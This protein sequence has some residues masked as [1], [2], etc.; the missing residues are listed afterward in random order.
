MQKKVSILRFFLTLLLALS[1]LNCKSKNDSSVVESVAKKEKLVVKAPFEMPQLEVPIFPENEV[2]ITAFGAVE[3]GTVK[4][5]LAIEKAISTCA[6][7][8]GGRVV[9]PKGKWLT[10]KI[11]LKSHIDLHISEGAELIF[12]DDPQDYLPAVSTS[13]EGLRCYNYSPLIYAYDQERIAI[14]GKGKIYAKMDTWKEWGKKPRSKN[15]MDALVDLYEL[16]YKD[17]PIDERRMEEGNG[18]LRPHF[19]QFYN[20][21]NVLIE[22]IK[23]E[24]SPFWV[25]HMLLSENIIIRG[26]EVNATGH[27]ND[28]VDLEFAKNVLIENCTFTQGDDVIAVKSGRNHD[29]W[30]VGVPSENIVVRN[31]KAYK[32]HNLLAIGSELSAGVQ[33]VYM[34]NCHIYQKEGY[35]RSFVMI[36]TNHRRG[37]F[38]RHIY[39]DNVS[40]KKARVAALEMH[41]DVLYQWRDLV[42][43]YDTVLTPISDIYLKNAV[44]EEAEYGVLAEANDG[45]PIENVF[46]ENVEIKNVLIAPE[47]IEGDVSL[48]KINVSYNGDH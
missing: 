24:N 48:N 44:L 21:K 22:D 46:L 7:D 28:G 45:L 29:A 6:R 2:N 16:A 42:S 10:G 9:I 32:G 5:T 20:C 37:G 3:G 38:V 11:H 19:I 12:S 30:R 33:N 1:M 41:T 34:S 14:T 23:I 18:K 31:C 13:W 39:V 26:I 27:N 43:T 40:G 35:N 25:V 8:G 15:H 4:N 17:V 47:K 36:K